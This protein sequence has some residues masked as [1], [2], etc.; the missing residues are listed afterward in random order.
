MKMSDD[1]AIDPFQFGPVLHDQFMDDLN[2]GKYDKI[3]DYP[4]QII[5]EEDLGHHRIISEEEDG[6]ATHEITFASK[7]D[8]ILFFEDRVIVQRKGSLFNHTVKFYAKADGF[9]MSCCGDTEKEARELYSYCLKD[10]CIRDESVGRLKE[11][12]TII[13][14][15]GPVVTGAI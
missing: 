15:T 12:L 11:V 9:N 10:Y 14:K 13:I 1:F 2:S 6:S 5:S 7:E 4:H 8:W 3:P